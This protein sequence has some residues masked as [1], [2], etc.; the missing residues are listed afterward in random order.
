[1][2][3]YC[4]RLFVNAR[5][6]QQQLQRQVRRHMVTK[7]QKNQLENDPKKA[8]AQH[9]TTPLMD[10]EL[11]QWRKDHT[12][13]EIPPSSSSSNDALAMAGISKAD[14]EDMIDF[15]SMYDP[16]IHL[17]D[18]PDFSDPRLNYEVATDLSTYLMKYIGVRGPIT[19]AEYMRQALT[20]PL[21]GYYTQPS[22]NHN[23]NNNHEAIDDESLFDNDWDLQDDDNNNNGDGE[24]FGP[25]GDFV[26]APEISQI[27]GECLCIWLILEWERLGCPPQIQLV[28][29]GPGRGTLMSDVLKTAYEISNGRF[30]QALIRGGG[31]HMV[32]VSPVL[33]SK[34]QATLSDNNHNFFS[35]QLTFIT[36]KYKEE[37]QEELG[38]ENLTWKEKAE[39][40]RL[41][42]ETEKEEKKETKQTKKSTSSLTVEWHTRLSNVPKGIPTFFLCQ[43]FIDAL[44]VHSFQKTEDGWRERLV[45]VDI[46][47]DTTN[48]DVLLTAKENKKLSKGKKK[49]RLRFVI[50]PDA[51]PAAKSLL[52][53]DKDGKMNSNDDDAQV[54]DILEV[55]PE[56]MMLVQDIASRI[57]ES[58]G[59]AVIVDY[60]SPLGTGDTLRA[61]SK[62]EQVHVLSHPG[63]V[64]VT[65]DV[66]FNALKQSISRKKNCQA[67]GSI[68]QGQFLASMGAVDR[69]L[70]LIEKDETTDEQAQELYNALERLVSP[71]HMGER[72]QVLALTTTPS[73]DDD[74]TTIHGFS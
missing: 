67:H 6:W 17:P 42:K 71:Q 37:I 73:N 34:Q 70:Q 69:V 25:R 61:F 31:I 39:Q 41:K 16:V 40:V 22:N 52:K 50:P 58:K 35:N 2:S 68:P 66:D 60:G 45:D 21:Y 59:A 20:H 7:R 44:P 63:Q 30:A 47:S 55:C 15:A 10:H 56:G 33:Q 57:E 36:E 72:Y 9:W 13:T 1:M 43:E 51:T 26:T 48:P 54:G 5:P 8:L 11:V 14:P 74:S 4:R 46:K 29:I 64:D 32:E 49:T 19:T 62:H 28:E 65:A 38:D 27:F 12:N 23:H 18:K 53:I 24:I 3:V